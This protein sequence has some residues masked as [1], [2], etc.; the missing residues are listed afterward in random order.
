MFFTLDR[1][2]VESGAKLD[3]DGGGYSAREGP[4][5]GTYREGGS[6]ASLGGNVA[7]KKY[8]GSFYIPHHPGSGGYAASGGSWI[9]VTAGAFVKVDGTLS[10]SGLF[11]SVGGGSG[12]SLLIYSPYLLGYG[13]I[14]CN[15][16]ETKT[17]C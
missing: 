14:I 15:G 8:Y 12:G 2:V 4:G 10:N 7:S 17:Y 9:N 3:G 5:A 11:G 16:G 13:Q 6:Y 1:I